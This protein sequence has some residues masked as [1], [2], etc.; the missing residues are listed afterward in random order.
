MRTPLVP[1]FA[2]TTYWSCALVLFGTG[3]C[4]GLWARLGD[5]FRRLK[6]GTI[7]D[8][9]CPRCWYCMRGVGTLTC[10][11]CGYVAPRL[12][13]LLRTRQRRGWMAFAA[14]LLA[15]SGAVALV[16]KVRRDGLVSLVP[17]AALVRVTP[18]TDECWAPTAAIFGEGPGPRVPVGVLATELQRRA[19]ARTLTPSQ[20]RVLLTRQLGAFPEQLEAVALV[21]DVWPRGR[22]VY[23][24]VVVPQVFLAGGGWGNRPETLCRLGSTGEWRP[25]TEARMIGAGEGI[26]IAPSSGDTVELQVRYTM[27]GETVFEGRLRALRL[28]DRP[29]DALRPVTDACE[30]RRLAALQPRVMLL[31]DGSLALAMNGG[32][33]T[34]TA[35]PHPNLPFAMSCS[36]IFAGREVASGTGEWRPRGTG[37]GLVQPARVVVAG[38]AWTEGRAVEPRRLLGGMHVVLTGDAGVACRDAGAET[39]WAGRYEFDQI[40]VERIK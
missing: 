32:A 33:G 23:A 28:V 20:W 13:K 21:R 16:P 11:E 9:H 7:R 4:L 17:S 6:A 24:F 19:D 27:D 14:V 8:P 39:Y 36:V 12:G 22:P 3:L 1:A 40:G 15:A 5:Y 26:G 18:M 10:P 2:D 25:H 38:F 30:E 35:C 34:R 29:E 31:A 37:W